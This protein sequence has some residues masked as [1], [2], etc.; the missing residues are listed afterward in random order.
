M[1][2]EEGANQA[3]EGSLGKD[4]E[5]KGKLLRRER[6]AVGT[7]QLLWEG[8][9]SNRKKVTIIS[10]LPFLTSPSLLSPMPSP[11]RPRLLSPFQFPPYNLHD[12]L[13]CLLI[14]SRLLPFCLHPSFPLFSFQFPPQSHGP[15]P[16][17]LLGRQT[18]VTL[19]P[20]V[21]CFRS[22]QSDRRI[23]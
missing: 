15:P 17:P 16:S 13:S 4:R 2:S 6:G 3:F 9:K 19:P 10:T 22:T 14:C 23:D 12:L 7:G 11:L 21:Q 1:Q 18:T 5:I 20:P 8:G